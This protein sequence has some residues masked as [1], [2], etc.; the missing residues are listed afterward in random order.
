M[1]VNFIDTATGY[2]DSEEKIGEAL[3][4]S[5]RQDIVIA[6]KS[7][8]SD[9][10]LFLE[11]VDLSLKRLQTDYID[12]YHLHGVNSE[13]KMKE[14]ME[15]GGAYEGLK[16]AIKEGKVR[17]PAFSSHHMPEA[18][19]LML[20]EKFDVV[21]IPFN[22]IDTEPEKE[23]IPLA[24]KMNLG[25]IAMKPL[26]GGLLEDAN[27]AFRYLAQFSGIV[28]DPGIEKA[29]EME[30]IVRV[31]EDPRIL[32]LE[33]KKKIEIIRQELGKEFC[34]RCDY[35]LP[36][37]QGV[38]ISLV[39]GVKSIVKRMPWQNAFDWLDPVI[40]KAQECTEC[41]ECLERCPYHLAIPEL[42]KKN[43]SFWEQCKRRAGETLS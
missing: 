15:P 18:K 38:P 24:R 17:Y 33:E 10:K 32:S 30:E 23:I 20:T 28:A 31:I 2:G 25:F 22:F 21:Q 27:L 19:K 5:R 8:A 7:P 39:L 9:K 13:E 43:I 14:V 40:E 26:G 6:S 42:L 12:I 4:A 35:C 36:C 29:E 11:H 37:P 3:K 41:E 16:E 1:G 34:H